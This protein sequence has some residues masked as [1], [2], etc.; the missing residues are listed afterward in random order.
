MP[1][2]G[3]RVSGTPDKVMDKSDIDANSHSNNSAIN[4]KPNID[5][6]LREGNNSNSNNQDGTK[7]SSTTQID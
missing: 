2:F 3:A 4:S 7:G 6:R 1:R 5:L